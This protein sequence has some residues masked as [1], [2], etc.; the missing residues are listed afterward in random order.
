MQGVMM[1]DVGQKE[2]NIWMNTVSQEA[3]SQN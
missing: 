2:S 1:N 3:L